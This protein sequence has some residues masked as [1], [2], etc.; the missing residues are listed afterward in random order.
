MRQHKFADFVVRFPW[1]FILL[2]FGVTAVFAFQLPKV[3]LDTEMKNQLPKDLPTRLNL[4]R[5]EKLFGGTDMA[6]IVVSTDDLLKPDTL[7]R[8]KKMTKDVQRIKEFDRV[9]SVFTAKDVRGEFG[10]MIVESAIR[11]IPKSDEQVSELREKL[12]KN[13][14]IYGNMI[15]KDFK[16]TAIIAFLKVGASDE[17]VVEKLEKVVADNPGPENTVV[18]GMPI[19]RVNLTKD[20]RKDMSRFLPIGLALMVVFLFICFRQIRG[21][22]LPFIM[23][24]MA[25]IVVVGMIPMLG[26]KFHMVTVI[27]P[28]ILLAVAN[29]YG[30]HIMARYQEDNTPG[31]DKSS[32][33]LAKNGIIRLTNPVLATGLT[34]MAGLLCLL[35]H[36]IIPAS[37]LGILAATGTAFAMVG[38]LVFIP[39]ILSL[40][41]KAKPVLMDRAKV[42][43]SEALLDRILFGLAERITRWPKAVILGFVVV[44]V[45][46]GIGSF[47]IVVDTNPLSFY[48]KDAPIWQSTRTLNDHLGGWAGISIVAEGDVKDP[49]LLVKVDE[50][51]KYLQKNK[52]VGN[53]TS[54][55]MMIRKMNQVMHDDDPKFDVIPD[56]RELVAQYFLLYS[57]NADPDDFS[58]IVDFNFKNTQLIAQVRESGTKSATE[59]VEYTKAYL[60]KLPNSPFKVVGGFLDVMADMVQHI[61]R[62]QVLSLLL[63]VIICAILVGLL[64]RSV[65]AG[66][67]AMLPLSIAISLLFGLMGYLGIE[68]NLITAM[69]SSIMVGVGID[70]TIHFLWRY[71]DERR[72]KGDVVAA[73]KSTLTTTGRGILFNALSVVVG[74]I[75]LLISSFFPVKFFGLLVV[76]SITACLICALV[77]LPAIVVVFKPKFLE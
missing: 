6:M 76:V 22:L 71:R 25:I 32:R 14:L 68:L 11:R 29:N 64:M 36:I 17:T 65:V 20:I 73:V 12:K 77:L 72:A 15:S 53:T 16:H 37:Q 54:I 4:D 1:L 31:N 9:L 21:V 33:E 46:M 27:L 45:T 48:D 59:V 74:F 50:L 49:K 10:E 19:V 44:A 30:I 41:P 18:G 67:I 60:E 26:W 62:G 38:S 8:I 63:S 28:V 66:I 61:V 35:S 75:V 42:G 52:L 3:K 34:T 47:F 13:D 24:V 39:A 43:D 7:K 51:D 69:L 5:I 70:Y 56:T 57:M 2:F 23:T 40:M 58:K 55:S